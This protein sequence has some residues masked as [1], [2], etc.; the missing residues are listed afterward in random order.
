MVTN[1]KEEGI[2]LPL[3]N[4]KWFSQRFPEMDEIRVLEGL[5]EN[6]K[7]QKLNSTIVVAFHADLEVAQI[8]HFF[9][10]GSYYPGRLL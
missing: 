1:E 6:W 2:P 3:L 5:G 10:P 8:K 9:P 4:E 7:K